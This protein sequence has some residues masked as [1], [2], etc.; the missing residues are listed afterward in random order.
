LIHD[1][2][3]NSLVTVDSIGKGLWRI[4][5]RYDDDFVSFEVALDIR[6]PALDITNARLTVTRN[7]FGASNDLSSLGQR[8]VGVRVGPG[9]T[10]IV[11]EIFSGTSVA[12]RFAELVL[13]A[14]EMLVN[15]IT[16]PELRKAV[17]LCG[18]DLKADSDGPRVFL[19]DRVIGDALVK[20]MAGNPRL[21]NSCVAFKED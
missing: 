15:A 14:M 7:E 1:F 20:N 16:V 3:V 9:M 5:T 2:Q 18:V 12:S 4:A 19:N 6:A 10:K 17:E 11:R 8:L 13:E 21:K